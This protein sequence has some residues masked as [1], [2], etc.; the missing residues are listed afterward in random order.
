[1][2]F[3]CLHAGHEPFQLGFEPRLVLVYESS[4]SVKMAEPHQ[5]E[6][7]SRTCWRHTN[8]RRHRPAGRQGA[9]SLLN[10]EAV[11]VAVLALCDGTPG[12]C[13]ADRISAAQCGL[14]LRVAS[15]SLESRLGGATWCHR[16]QMKLAGLRK[17]GKIAARRWFTPNCS[18]AAPAKG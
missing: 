17:I 9:L 6:L 2:G 5:D 12:H 8:R 10:A 15:P 7:R 18:R 13:L 1:M 16:R 14:L 4:H 3:A 11:E